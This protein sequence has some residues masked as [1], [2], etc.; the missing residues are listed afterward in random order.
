MLFSIVKFIYQVRN[1]ATAQRS[2]INTTRNAVR[3]TPLFNFGNHKMVAHS[4]IE[5]KVRAEN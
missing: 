4:G 2:M 5:W 1:A 3:G